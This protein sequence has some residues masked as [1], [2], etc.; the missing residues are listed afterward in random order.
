MEIPL[1]DLLDRLAILSLKVA[2]IDECHAE[3][4]A[5]IEAVGK[6]ATAETAGWLAE[7]VAANARIW[8]LEADIR[9]GR[10]GE[11]PLE[12]VGRRALAIRE[13]NKERVGIKARI[14]EASG[15]G[16]PDIKGNHASAETR[17]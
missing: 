14:T 11:M 5:Y 4:T 12:E 2:R 1:A 10:D 9:A 6:I 13:R 8:D 16:W 7:L 3:H 15:Q 17:A